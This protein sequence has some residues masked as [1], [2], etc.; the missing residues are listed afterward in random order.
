MDSLIK[1]SSTAPYTI[2]YMVET[3]HPRISLTSNT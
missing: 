1:L 2:S 3:R